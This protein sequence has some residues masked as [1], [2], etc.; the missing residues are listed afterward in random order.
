MLGGG[1]LA[2]GGGGLRTQDVSTHTHTHTRARAHLLP[3][4]T[5]GPRGSEPTAALAAT[6][7]RHDAITRMTAAIV[8]VR[9]ASAAIRDE[10]RRAGS[11]RQPTQHTQQQ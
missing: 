10:R 2:P 5:P 7:L 1:V 9:T 3:L 8:T 11:G 4:L 6:L